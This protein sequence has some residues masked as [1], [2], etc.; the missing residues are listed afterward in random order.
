[1]LNSTN[2][3][4]DMD[5]MSGASATNA[6]S[7]MDGV[8][9]ASATNGR[10]DVDGVSGASTTSSARGINAG[11]VF[12]YGSA[13][14]IYLIAVASQAQPAVTNQAQLITTSQS[15]LDVTSETQSATTSQALTDA[16]EQ[17]NQIEEIIVWGRSLKMLGRAQA[18]SEGVVGYGDFSVRPLSRVGELVEVVPGMMATQ[19]SG[20]GKANQ[21]FLRG[22]NLDHGSDFAI[23][24]EGMPVN[25]RTHAHAQGYMDLNFIIPEVVEQVNFR[26]GPH[27]ATIGDFSLAGSGTVKTYDRLEQGFAELAFGSGDDIRFVTADSLPYRDGT[28][29]YA[30]EHHQTN[31][32]FVLDQDVRKY[33][34]LLKYSGMVLGVAGRITLSA[35]DASWASTNQVPRRAV[36]NGLIS[37]LGH[38]DP[39]LGG[40]SRRHSLTGSFDLNDWQLSL[41]ASSYYMSL[42]NNP[43]YFLNDP[44]YGDEFEQEDERL[45]LGGQLTHQANLELSTIP[46]RL[47]SGVEVRYDDV[48]EL[49]LFNTIGS[50]RINIPGTANNAGRKA[51]VREDEAEE[52][53]LAAFVEL[54]FNLSERLRGNLGLRME[55]YRYRVRALIPEN[56]GSDKDELV[57]PKLSLAYR[58]GDA[59]ELYAARGRGFHSND[60]R[61]AFT[62]VDPVTGD[63]AETRDVLIAG[64]GSEIGLRYD[65]A[66]GFNISLAYFELETG[67]ELVFVGDAG[68]TEPADP[69]RRHGLELNAFWEI[70]NQLVLDVS[71]ATTD[72]HFHGLPTGENK[73]PDAQER[74]LAAGLSWVGD[75]GFVASLRLRHFG[76]AVLTGDGAI[77]NGDSTLMNLGLS[78]RF[79]NWELG[80]D[81]LN[82]F[83]AEDDDIA[84]YF[85]SQL[86]GE[87]RPVDDIHFHPAEPR[88]VRA[89]LRYR[90]R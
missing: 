50:R 3:R 60:I 43:T 9:G 13:I 20:P 69:A 14:A 82:L 6:R 80:V 81:V 57:L 17:A 26:K 18:A 39:D 27:S 58:I 28:L 56:S 88:A 79:D 90:F 22:I 34:A 85:A 32:Q 67:S 8:S 30:L 53:S 16:S 15:Q 2:G 44:V 25:L 71:A 77:R 63:P 51:S 35:Y 64:N 40:K 86:K 47:L 78:Y 68:T 66:E 89:L 7:D 24:F 48:N 84:Y 11:R 36:N 83:D 62:R 42:I 61:V 10:S 41:Y 59:L 76:E 73:I 37:R 5:G 33:N 72:G 74:V 12:V 23:W 75:N 21:Y 70:N 49:N 29:L 55:H 19:H 38:I 54:R 52:L 65:A 1:M 4:S 46:M 31:G 45:L 87:A